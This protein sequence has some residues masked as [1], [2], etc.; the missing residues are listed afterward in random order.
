MTKPKGQKSEK[1]SPVWVKMD[2]KRVKIK[3]EN[4]SMQFSSGKVYID[5]SQS[6]VKFGSK[7][8]VENLPEMIALAFCIPN[9]W[10]SLK[11]SKKS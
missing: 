8:N 10:V 4:I 2:S 11:I 9:L 5:W 1:M 3:D 7:Q 6:L